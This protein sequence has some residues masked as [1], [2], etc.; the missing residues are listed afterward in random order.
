VLAP[1]GIDPADVVVAIDY[2]IQRRQQVD[3]SIRVINLSLGGGGYSCSCDG[4]QPA[5]AETISDAAAAGIVSFAATG[6]ESVCGGIISPACVSAAV[7]VAADYDDDYDVVIYYW[8][9]GGLQCADFSEPYWVTCFSNVAEDCDWFLAAPG[10]DITVGGFSGEG[11][12]QATA[13]CSGVAALMF[14]QAP[15]GMDAYTARS[16]IW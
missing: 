14:D 2:V 16:I 9:E 1:S 6:N 10:Y 11:T 4:E 3:P 12:S 8:P 13:H 7:R 5:V 15:C